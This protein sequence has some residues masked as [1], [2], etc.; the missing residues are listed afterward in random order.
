MGGETCWLLRGKSVSNG[1]GG[2]VYLKKG[3][4]ELT[5]CR[6][7]GEFNMMLQEGRLCLDD[8]LQG[9]ISLNP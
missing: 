9:V 8:L 4:I 6:T 7:G 1:P 2:G 5:F 3:P